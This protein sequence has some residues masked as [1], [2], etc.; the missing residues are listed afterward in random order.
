MGEIDIE[1]EG[2]RGRMFEALKGGCLGTGDS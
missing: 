1:K 2:A